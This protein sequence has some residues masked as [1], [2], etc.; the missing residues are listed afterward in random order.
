MRRCLCHL[1]SLKPPT[2]NHEGDDEDG[3]DKDGDDNGGDVVMMIL[4]QLAVTIT[5]SLS[6]NM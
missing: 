2:H 3:D 4:L 5:Q 6:C 1:Q